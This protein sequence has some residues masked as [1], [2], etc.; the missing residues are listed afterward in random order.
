LTEPSKDT[1]GKNLV[2]FYDSLAPIYDLKYRNPS[3]EYMKQIEWSIIDRCTRGRQMRLLDLGCGT[4]SLAV[5]LANR[6][7]DVVGVDISP[8]MV[9]IARRKAAEANVQSRTQF[10]VANIEE[11]PPLS[12]AFD[13]AYSAFGAFNHVRDL[14]AAIQGVGH[15]LSARCRLFISLASRMGIQGMQGDARSARAPWKKIEMKE[16]GRAVWTRFYTRDE[17]EAALSESGLS[18]TKVGG[19]FYLVRPSYVQSNTMHFGLKQRL[20]AR[21]ESLIRWHGPANHR[22]TYLLFLAEKAVPS[23]SRS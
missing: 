13:F 15:V 19:V 2:Q 3:I 16:V 22:A 12:G 10:L 17:V 7:N 18:L 21:A 23:E 1:L 9:A 4:G 6:G 20:M 5:K 11:L 14:R 8:E